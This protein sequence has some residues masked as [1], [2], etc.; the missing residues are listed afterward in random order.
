MHDA[1]EIFAF[2]V[3]PGTDEILAFTE[4]LRLARQEASEHFDGLRQIG[5]NVDAGI[6]IY[7]IGL[8]DPRL[9]DFVTVLNDPED[10]SER[11]IEKMERVEVI[12]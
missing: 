7:K 5:A 9:A 10:M 12:T 4:T 2:Q 8:K 1:K 6:A 11:L 3:V